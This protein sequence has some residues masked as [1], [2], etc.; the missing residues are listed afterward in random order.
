MA[1]ACPTPPSALSLRKRGR[2][3]GDVAVLAEA[4]G[5]RGV[6]V[7]VRVGQMFAIIVIRRAIMR[8]NVV[9]ESER[10]GVI[11]EEVVA[12]PL[13]EMLEATEVLIQLMPKLLMAAALCVMKEGTRKLIVLRG[14]VAVAVE[15][16]GALMIDADQEAFLGADPGVDPEASQ[17]HLRGP[18]IQKK[19]NCKLLFYQVCIFTQ[20]ILTLCFPKTLQKVRIKV[21]GRFEII[22][23]K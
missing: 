23:K 8:E 21:L 9:R 10:G 11:G 6:G 12:V 20:S 3:A 1:G 14:E 19:R 2:V 22:V 17:E 13:E 5:G 16:A 18:G 7:G 15:E 4:V